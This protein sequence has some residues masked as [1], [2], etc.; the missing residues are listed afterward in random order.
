MLFRRQI[1]LYSF[2]SF[3]LIKTGFLIML[4]DVFLFYI[5]FYST[6]SNYHFIHIHNFDETG[7]R[8]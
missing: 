7:D 4:A 1:P 3:S 2:L 5:H 6:L 8:M